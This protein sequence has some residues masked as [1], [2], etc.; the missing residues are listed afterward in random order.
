MSDPNFANIFSSCVQSRKVFLGGLAQTV[1]EGKLLYNKISIFI[2]NL[3]SYFSKFGGLEQCIIMREKNTKKSRGFGFIVFENKSSVDKLIS[4]KSKHVINGKSVECKT[5]VA[6]DE[7]LEEQ[8]FQKLVNQIPDR[9]GNT[10]YSFLNSQQN[11]DLTGMNESC[12]DNEMN[13]TNEFISTSRTNYV[14]KNKNNVANVNVNTN[15]TSKI[16]V[17]NFSNVYNNNFKPNNILNNNNINNYIGNSSNFNLNSG[18]KSNQFEEFN[19]KNNNNNYNSN[20]NNCSNCS[21]TNNNPNSLESVLPFLLLQQQQNI[22]KKNNFGFNNFNNMMNRSLF[23][24]INNSSLF[25]N[26]PIIHNNI[27]KLKICFNF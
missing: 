25:G 20:N 8:D 10:D 18:L 21:S 11:V 22:H 3:N 13:L 16:P 27:C 5:A 23:N 26:Q 4:C 14:N 24:G 2:D 19:Q 12:L 6:K 7:L 17:N 15:L 1:T 9:L